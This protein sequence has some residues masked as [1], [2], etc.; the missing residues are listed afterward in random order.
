MRDNFLAC[1]TV[2]ACCAVPMLVPPM[3]VRNVE[4]ERKFVGLDGGAFAFAPAPFA[5]S[6][7]MHR[8]PDRRIV[9][10]S[11]GTGMVPGGWEAEDARSW[12]S[13]DWAG[14]TMPIML[15]SQVRYAE[16]IMRKM[17]GDNRSVMSHYLRLNPSI[18][19]DLEV[20]SV[21]SSEVV[22]RL[23]TI[24]EQL[25]SDHRKDITELMARLH[26]N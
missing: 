24:G 7:V 19:P 2:M 6:E 5:V 8:Y 11:L 9:M 3:V 14:A 1:D 10:L 23:E 13:I 22:D 18:P 21:Q 20:V 12:G 16:E 15:R 26:R 25:V 4:G 17:A